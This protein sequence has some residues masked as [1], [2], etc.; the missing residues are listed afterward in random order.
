VP[1]NPELR[2]SVARL[3]CG[4]LLLVLDEN[5]VDEVELGAAEL[6]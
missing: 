1:S 6:R 4:L 2:V 5:A 3:L